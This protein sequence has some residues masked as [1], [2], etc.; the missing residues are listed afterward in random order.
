MNS[1]RSAAPALALKID[2]DTDHGCARGLPALL[3]ILKKHDL[4][5]SFFLSLGPDNMGKSIWRVFTEPGFLKTVR[6]RGGANTYGWSILFKG[7]LWPGPILWKKHRALFQQIAADGHEVGVHAWDHY[8]W[9]RHAPAFTDTDVQKI[10]DRMAGAFHEIFQ[11]APDCA[12]APGWRCAAPMLA[13]A[14]RLKLRYMSDTRGTTPFRPR[15]NKIDFQT[16]QLPTTL[17][18]L[19]E[20]AGSG[21]VPREELNTRLWSELKPAGFNLYTLHAEIEGLG[22]QDLFDTFLTGVKDRGYRLTTLGEAAA[23]LPQ[24]LPVCEVTDEI[25]SG[26]SAPVSVAH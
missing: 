18:T 13:L 16:P 4:R 20:L 23:A 3:R 10:W 14:D 15:L 19:D 25:L 1:E 7:F 22:Y 6:R 17:T 12:A 2:I 26:R 11:R 21:A 5:A 9:Q 24:P 8:A